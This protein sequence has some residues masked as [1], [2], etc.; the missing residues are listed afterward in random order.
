MAKFGKWIGGGLGFVLGGPIGA[1]IGFGLGSFFDGGN[2]PVMIAGSPA[3]SGDF[4]V[5]LLVLVAAVMKADGKVL[6]SELDYVKNYFIQSFGISSATQL[7]KILGEIIKKDIP[8]YEVCFQIKAHM[9]YS[10]RL[11]LLH[12]LFGISKSDGE[13]V[14]SELRLIENI[15]G[16]LGIGKMDFDSIKSMFV[17]LTD[18]SYKVLEIEIGSTNEEVKAAYRSMAKKYH[19]DKVSYLG[20]DIQKAAMEKFK[21]V[22]EAYEKIRKERSMA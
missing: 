8:V 4:T 18:S 9:D 3:T 13:I 12:F 10:S 21:K 1:I 16:Y 14:A 15:S 17:D 20:E 19:P 2:E 7:V 22:N 11:E 6:R 5:S